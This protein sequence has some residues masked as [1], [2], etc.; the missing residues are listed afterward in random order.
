MRYTA[1][2]I[3]LPAM[4]DSVLNAMACVISKTLELP[5]DRVM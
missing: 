3:G 1:E 2:I 5:A 4:Q